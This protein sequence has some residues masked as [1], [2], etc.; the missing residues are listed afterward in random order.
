M[1]VTHALS[2][3]AIV[4]ALVAFVPTFTVWAGW[5]TPAVVI[6][7][8]FVVT[9]AALIPDLDNSVSTAKNSLGLLGEALSIFFR[10]TSR[11]I[12][13]VV[14]TSRDDASPDP[15]RGFWHT[16]PAALILG[17]ATWLLTGITKS[18]VLPVV[19]EVTYGWIGALVVA[20]IS[21][22][23]AFAG[24]FSKVIKKVLSKGKSFEAV[25]VFAAIVATLAVF[26]SL[27]RDQNFWWLSVAV[28]IGMIAHILGDSFTTAGVPLLFPLSAPLKGKFWWTTRFS[29]MKA[30]GPGE[31]IWT[32]AFGIISVGSLVWIFIGPTLSK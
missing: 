17:G 5:T 4:L 31:V 29:S 10:G 3:L 13:T 11:F 6:L 23:L 32:W 27:P 9:G 16:I 20:Y 2:G 24:L 30:G 21:I 19:G 25:V 7:A 14:R 22:H 8:A 12:Q 26:Y 28:T 1:G 15:H 18:I